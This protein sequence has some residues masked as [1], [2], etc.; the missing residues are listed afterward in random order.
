MT[1]R[2][3]LLVVTLMGSAAA[4]ANSLVNESTVADPVCLEVGQKLDGFSKQLQPFYIELNDKLVVLYDLLL[5]WDQD[6]LK[7]EGVPIRV[8]RGKFDFIRNSAIEFDDFVYDFE[9]RIESLEEQFEEYS[10][11]IEQCYSEH[12]DLAIYVSEV[13]GDHRDES[14]GFIGNIAGILFDWHSGWQKF[15]GQP[16]EIT[17]SRGTFK[18]IGDLA[19]E[20][21]HVGQF[22]VSKNSEYVQK[23]I[24]ELKNVILESQP[25]GPL[26]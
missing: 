24:N 22:Y 11:V 6:L 12:E 17:F 13:I 9:G 10:E 5:K 4:Q 19:R 15:E 8:D 16:K 20:K 26:P 18:K 23:K 21:V 14:L 25:S 2:V 1:M 3:L 7:W